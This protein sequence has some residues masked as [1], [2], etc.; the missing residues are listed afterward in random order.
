MYINNVVLTKALIISRGKG[1]LS[2][3]ASKMLFLIAKNAGIKKIHSYTDQDNY[4]DCLM[5]AYLRMLEVWKSY[6]H[7]KFD[8]PFAYFTEI[9]KRG[10]SAEYHK[11]VLKK[12]NNKDEAVQYIRMEYINEKP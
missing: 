12:K 9:F 6:D 4:Y 8:N 2:D 10:F 3:D 7:K 11:V 1:K 5:G